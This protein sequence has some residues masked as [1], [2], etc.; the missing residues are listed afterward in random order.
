M[1]DMHNH[2]LFDTDDGPK[3]IEES[4]RMIETAVEAGFDELMLTPHYFP[5]GP[6]LKTTKENTEKFELLKRVVEKAGIPVKLFLGSEIMYAYHVPDLVCSGDFK[7][8]G[9]TC[10]FLLET[11]RRG[12]TA[13]GLLGVVRK[14]EQMGFSSVFAHPERVDFVQEE[15]EILLD[16]IS[17]GCL[18]QCNYLSL[19]DYYGPAPERTIRQLLE[20][21]LVHTIGSDAHQKEAYELWPQADERGKA[22]AGEDSWKRITMDNPAK[23]LAG[24]KLVTEAG[25]VRMTVSSYLGKTDLGIIFE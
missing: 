6:Y 21:G 20:M 7:T 11:Q 15:P 25:P 12:A 10:Y 17:R 8:L 5:N 19:T 13:E 16:F 4:V 22:A 9:D 1:I 24:E 3:E 18:I 14:L 2:I 23:L